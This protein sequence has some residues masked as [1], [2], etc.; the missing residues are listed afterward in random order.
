MSALYTNYS[1]FLANGPGD[2]VGC[3]AICLP[4]LMQGV[5]MPWKRTYRHVGK[6]KH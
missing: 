1:G 3:P 5:I 4:A 6:I 2:Y